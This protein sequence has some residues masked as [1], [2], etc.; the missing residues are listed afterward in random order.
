MWT[1]PKTCATPKGQAR[2]GKRQESDCEVAVN[3]DDPGRHVVWEHVKRKI[4]AGPRRTRTEAF[5]EWAAD[6]QGEVYEI[7]EADAEKALRFGALERE[8]RRMAREVKKAGRYKR[9]SPEELA[10]M[11]AA[12]PF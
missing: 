10:E 12:V 2:D 3:I 7:Q 11:L 1:R 4:K 5:Y 8:E 6:H 9:R